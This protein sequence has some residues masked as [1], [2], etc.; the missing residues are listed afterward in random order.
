MVVTIGS[1]AETVKTIPNV[2]V[3]AVCPVA[4]AVESEADNDMAAASPHG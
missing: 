3:I 1:V 4:E 2:A